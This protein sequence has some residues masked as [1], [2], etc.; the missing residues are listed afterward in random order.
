LFFS[1]ESMNHK[2]RVILSELF[3]GGKD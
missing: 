3:H 2:M 1:L